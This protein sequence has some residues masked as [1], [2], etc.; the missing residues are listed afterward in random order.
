MRIINIVDR[1]DRVNF[2][3]WNAATASCEIL[4]R[5]F[6]CISEIWFPEDKNMPSESEFHGALP[7]ILTDLNIESVKK[8]IKIK[9][10][11]PA[12]TLVVSHGCWRFPTL[13]GLEFARLGFK[14]IYT[15]HGMLEPW[16]MHSKRIKK[17]IYFKF[18]EKPAVV[19]SSGIRVVSLPEKKHIID[20]FSKNSNIQ[21][22]P[23]GAEVPENLY[24]KSGSKNTVLFL[25]RLNHKKG[26]CELASA[27]K[28]SQLFN[29]QNFELIFAGPDDGELENLKKIVSEND[30][31]KILPPVKGKDKS[32]LF[33]KARF[34]FLPSKSEGFASSAVESMAYG[35]IPILTEQCN[36]IEVFQHKFG[37]K[38]GY[39]E[40]EILKTLNSLVE[41]VNTQN[42]NQLSVDVYNFCKN[43]FSESIVAEKLFEFYQSIL[44]K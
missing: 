14:W 1:I 23:N 26:V 24:I 40:N 11:N 31:I 21:Y 35:C 12:D 4:Y 32:N 37:I 28:K 38:T 33:K 20:I 25:G 18:A 30:N 29:N 6:G 19:M 43:N 5:K 22:V 16:C 34:F 7:E 41:F 8:I 17:L 36:F 10:L 15:P 2:G 13:W 39:T 9:N 44:K 27:W 3:I 42:I